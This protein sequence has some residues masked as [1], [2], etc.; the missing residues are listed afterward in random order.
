MFTPEKEAVLVVSGKNPRLYTEVMNPEDYLDIC[1]KVKI[2]ENNNYNNSQSFI[3][4]G[5]KVRSFAMTRPISDYPNITIS[6][7]KTPPA[8]W[9]QIDLVDALKNITKNNYLIVGASGAGK[10]YLMNYLLK[11]QHKDSDSKIGL[12]E[13]FSELFSP[14]KS[15]S[16]LTVPPNKPGQE[17]L[18]HYI[19]EMSNLMR[20]DYIYIGEIKGSEAWPFLINLSSGTRGAATMHG[21]SAD[22]GLRRLLNLCLTTG[23]PE[24]VVA[25]TIAKSIDYIIYVENHEIR[26]IKKLTGIFN[27]GIFQSIKIW[28]KGEGFDKGLKII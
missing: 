20:F 2:E 5:I 21:S 6:T 10:T 19:T 15:T 13:E 7:S 1:K 26:E 23:I 22:H 9:D 18:L 8:T 25:D 4:G 24:K 3:M 17:R 16:V 28:S 12:I 27:N 11:E 14:N